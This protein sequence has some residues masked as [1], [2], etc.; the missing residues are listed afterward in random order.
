MAMAARPLTAL[1][2]VLFTVMVS[3]FFVD[4]TR[5]TGELVF[6]LNGWLASDLIIVVKVIIERF[7]IALLCY[8]QTNYQASLHKQR[9]SSKPNN[10][11]T[12]TFIDLSRDHQ[13][14]HHHTICRHSAAVS[15]VLCK[16][17]ATH[18]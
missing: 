4:V 15:A 17:F 11:H 5:G 8:H 12:H 13:P 14:E 18:I 2:V 1:G 10:Q 7:A 6:V 9:P 3:R 16:A